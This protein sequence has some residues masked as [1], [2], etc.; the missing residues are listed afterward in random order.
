MKAVHNLAV[1]STIVAV[2]AVVTLIT[3]VVLH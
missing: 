1:Y 3:I 2:F